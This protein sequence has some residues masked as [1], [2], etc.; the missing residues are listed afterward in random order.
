MYGNS[1]YYKHL[2]TENTILSNA[3]HDLQNEFIAYANEKDI[4][5]DNLPK[6]FKGNNINV[7]ED[8]VI[9]FKQSV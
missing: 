1:L 5:L 6:A 3:N 8:N 2:A 9:D 7:Q 4:S